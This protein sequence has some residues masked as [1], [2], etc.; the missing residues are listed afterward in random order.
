MPR[1]TNI[2]IRRGSS[3]EW[4]NANPI[5]DSGEPGYDN[6]KKALK[7]GDS[8]TNWNDLPSVL[9]GSNPE[10]AS[11]VTQSNLI[12]IRSQLVNFK[13]VG[14]TNMLT[15]PAGC[16]FLINTMEVLTTSISSPNSPPVVRFGKS[17]SPDEFYG[18]AIAYTNSVGQ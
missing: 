17:S 10:L 8:A 6:T 18:P 12:S 1:I 2:K 11:G 7:I 5:L 4:A 16:M 14:E 13:S 9:L 3:T 15:V